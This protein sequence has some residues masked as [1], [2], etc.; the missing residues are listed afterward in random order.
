MKFKLFYRKALLCNETG[1]RS[2]WSRRASGSSSQ[3]C[4]GHCLEVLRSGAWGTVW[5]FFAVVSGAL[6]AMIRSATLMHKSPATCSDSGKTNNRRFI[7]PLLI[8][9]EPKPEDQDH[10]MPV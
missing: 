1:R 2:E 5:K 8:S 4:L 3:W 10:T 9:T 7:L 6:C